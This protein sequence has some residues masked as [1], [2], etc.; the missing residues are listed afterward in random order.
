MKR[1]RAVRCAPVSFKTAENTMS[2]DSESKERLVPAR[3]AS[4]A[5]AAAYMP[6]LPWRWL[7]VGTLA[8]VTVAGGYW[9]KERQRAETLRG[10]ILRVHEELKE[11]SARYL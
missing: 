11:P 5:E 6:K 3:P 8:I 4:E 1:A 2:S 10:Q 9:L 7:L